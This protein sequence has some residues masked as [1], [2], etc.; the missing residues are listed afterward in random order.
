[1]LV[2][3][4]L[5][6]LFAA[7]LFPRDAGSPLAK[8]AMSGDP[9]SRRLGVYYL[10]GAVAFLGLAVLCT[11]LSAAALLLLWPAMST[12]TRWRS[13]IRLKSLSFA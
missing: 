3:A 12:I 5:L 10:C 13:L 1:M 6:G 7:W 8:F 11:P 9:K 2:G 4:M